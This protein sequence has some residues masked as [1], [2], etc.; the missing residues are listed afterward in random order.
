ML[1]FLEYLILSI[2]Y[3]IELLVFFRMRKLVKGRRIIFYNLNMIF[4]HH[5]FLNSNIQ[6]AIN[7]A[8]NLKNIIKG[9]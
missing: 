3:K 2:D 8:E 9:S 5:L 7:G 1:I 4:Y 6:Y